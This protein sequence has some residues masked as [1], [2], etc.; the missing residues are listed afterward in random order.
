MTC[1]LWHIE[2]MKP[3]MSEPLTHIAAESNLLAAKQKDERIVVG[4]CHNCG[5]MAV[6]GD[7]WASLLIEGNEV[8]DTLHHCGECDNCDHRDISLTLH[9]Y[10]RVTQMDEPNQ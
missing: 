9:L 7:D 1:T 10:Q 4:S 3:T 6:C 5:H 2:I 8:E